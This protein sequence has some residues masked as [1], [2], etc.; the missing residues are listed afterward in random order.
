MKVPGSNVPSSVLAAVIA[1]VGLVG[2]SAVNAAFAPAVV[3][4]APTAIGLVDLEK[5]IN[6]LAEVEARNL[7]NRTK[8]EQAQAR[9]DAARA[10]VEKAKNAVEMVPE[11]D[12]AGR[13]AGM[14][15]FRQ[16]EMVLK[17]EFE[18]EQ[19]K[20]NLE[21]GDFIR[22]LYAKIQSA[23]AALAAQ[24]GLDLIVL[25]DR[26]VPLPDGADLTDT[27][28]NGVIQQKKVLFA[29]NSVD[30]TPALATL[31]NNQWKAQGGR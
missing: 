3:E 18:S 1:A 4:R 14:L 19:L 9:I 26:G 11:T 20:L 7:T 6:Q 5:L 29:S 31:M 15:A 13:R 22:E 30:V 28:I 25:D 8:A 16:A 27:Q 2:Y 21:K 23:C 24:Q 17:A 12:K 10:Q